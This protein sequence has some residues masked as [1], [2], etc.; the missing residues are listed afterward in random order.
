LK[1]SAVAFASQRRRLIAFFVLYPGI[2]TSYAKAFRT[3]PPTHFRLSHDKKKQSYD[4]LHQ[5]PQKTTHN[6]K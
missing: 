2:G 1:S 6:M 4:K 5:S 3:S